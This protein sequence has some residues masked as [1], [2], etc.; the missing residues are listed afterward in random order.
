[1]TNFK[2]KYQIDMCRG[3]LFYKIVLFAVP[4]ILSSI[5]QLLFNAADLIVIGR[6]APHEAMAAVGATASLTQL[7]INI[8]IGF[9]VGTNVLVANFY[10]A[11]DRKNISRTV[12]TAIFLSLT[13]GLVMALAGLVLAKPMLILMA[14]PENVLPK[15]CVYMW[16]YFAGMPAIMLYNFGS[17]V[18]RAVGDT[19]RPLYF[20]LLAGFVNVIL[21]LFFVLICGMDVGGVALA[22]MISQGIAGV[23]VLR[24]LMSA[25]DACRVRLRNLRID[26]GIL[27]RMLWIGLPA[28]IQGS[29][30]SLSNITIQSTINSFGSQAIAGTT[31]AISLEGFGQI[32]SD[33]FHQAA[34]CFTGQNLGGRQFKRI[35]QSV[36]YCLLSTFVYCSIMGYGMLFNGK[37]LLGI[38]TS[39]PEIIT[40]GILRMKFLFTTLFICGAMNVICGALRGLGHSVA[41]AVTT[42]LGACVLR[43]VWVYTIFPLYPSMENLLLSYPI[44]WGLTA[45]ANALCLYWVYKKICSQK[46]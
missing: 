5:V 1:M 36:I 28:G 32:G 4:L 26:P 12:H 37:Y 41:P 16:I 13:G 27:K 7:I 18:L 2:N 23:L 29:F 6:F 33:A 15:A 42:F 8:F 45:I 14:T 24:C 38:F 40:W 39:A 20:L 43:I 22:T 3:P 44:S 9:S 19:R 11:K 46:N 31:A 30:F 17:A 34:V 10:G 25:R 21:N 35:R